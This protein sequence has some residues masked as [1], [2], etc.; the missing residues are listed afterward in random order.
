VKAI[1]PGIAT[2]TSTFGNNYYG[3]GHDYLF[4]TKATVIHTEWDQAHFI[5]Q[6]KKVAA[7][8]ALD[9]RVYKVVTDQHMQNFFDCARNGKEPICPFELG[10][11]TSIACQMAVASYPRQATVRWDAATE[12][13][14]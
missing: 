8:P 5:P 10:F 6:G 7:R 1:V 9:D 11:R 3:E 2:F 13:I 12:E 14:I 4:G